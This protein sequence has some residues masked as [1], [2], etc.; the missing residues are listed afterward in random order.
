MKRRIPLITCEELLHQCLASERVY[1]HMLL[2]HDDEVRLGGVEVGLLHLCRGLEL[3]ESYLTLRLGEAVHEYALRS[4]GRLR[5]RR[6]QVIG[7][8]VEAQLH[9][10]RFQLNTHLA[11]EHRLMLLS[12]EG[13]VLLVGCLPPLLHSL[14][15]Q[16]VFINRKDFYG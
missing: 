6:N 2:G 8:R 1:E 9:W 13:P 15:P 12:R 3:M 16:W 7:L 14:R 10:L 4:L 5:L 11:L